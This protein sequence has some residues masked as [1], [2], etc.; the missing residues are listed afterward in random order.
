[1]KATDLLKKQHAKTKAALEKLSEGKG[2]AAEGKAAADELVAHMMI[3]EHVFYPRIRELMPDMVGESF[4]EHTVARF[5]LARALTA[6]GDEQKARFTVLKE[7]IEHHVKEEEEEMFPKVDK[8]IDAA[9]LERL[10][11]KM[12]AMFEKGA[13]AGFASMMGDDVFTTT[14]PK[15][16]SSKPKSPSRARAQG[17]SASR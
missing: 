15:N 11:A 16:A 7:L 4:E 6:K 10:G 13:A 2:T 8:K 3:E 1:M 12:E 9:E 14:A 17:M 5:E